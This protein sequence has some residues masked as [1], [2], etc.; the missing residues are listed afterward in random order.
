MYF[1]FFPTVMQSAP[2][3]LKVKNFNRRK[4]MLRSK[5]QKAIV[6]FR[7]ALNI[8]MNQHKKNTTE[9]FAPASQKTESSGAD[10]AKIVKKKKL[11]RIIGRPIKN[12]ERKTWE[13][14]KEKKKNLN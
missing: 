3:F 2:S 5:K 6:H 9:L 14:E 1:V 12:A 11:S 4:I 8:F 7:P 13:R 10:Y